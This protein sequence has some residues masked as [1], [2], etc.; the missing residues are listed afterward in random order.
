MDRY[1]AITG[2]HVLD[3]QCGEY[4]VQAAEIGEVFKHRFDNSI[5]EI[6]RLITRREEYRQRA[7]RRD[8]GRVTDVHKSSDEQRTVWVPILWPL[9]KTKNRRLLAPRSIEVIAV[10]EKPT[11]GKVPLMAPPMPAMRTARR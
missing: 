1:Y 3:L 4:G 5:G 7:D 2:R 10:S 8:I 11:R 9:Y 6:V